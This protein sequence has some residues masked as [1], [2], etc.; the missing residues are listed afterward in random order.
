MPGPRPSI[1]TLLTLAVSNV[2][3]SID[4][5]RD[6]QE[7]TRPDFPTFQEQAKMWLERS[8][9]TVQEV[10]RSQW[11]ER[12]MGAHV[13]GLLH[14]AEISRREHKLEEALEKCIDAE[15]VAKQ[16]DFELGMQD[17]RQ[18]RSTIEKALNGPKLS[19]TRT[20]SH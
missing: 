2:A 6:P 3:A 19:E 12:C 11:D 18:R 20:R 14:S 4:E 1:I 17:A 13:A 15:A 7:T 10:P 16:W 8:Q 9:A 5:R